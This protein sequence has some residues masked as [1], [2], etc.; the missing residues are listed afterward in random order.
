MKKQYLGLIIVLLIILSVLGSFILYNEWP[1]LTGEK[2]VLAT[3]PVDPFDPFRGQYMTIGY[4]ISMISG[5]SGFERGDSIY[6]LLEEDNESI[7]RNSGVS[8]SKPSQGTFIKGRVTNVYGD[9]VNVEYGIE[10]FFFEK[11][12]ELPTTNITI[13]AKVTN[14]GRAGLSQML[15]NGKPIEIKYKPVSIRS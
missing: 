10:Q 1:L 2:V 12:A 9:S 11:N 8:G 7:W 6:V 15:Y 14:S 3:R 4:E 5:V 13:E